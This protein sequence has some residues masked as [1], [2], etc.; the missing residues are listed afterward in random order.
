MDELEISGKRYLSTK[1]AGKQHG[2]H[3]DYIGQLIRG[4]KVTGQKVGRAWYV[5]AQSL[6]Q[7]LDKP[8]HDERLEQLERPVGPAQPEEPEPIEEPKEE[9]AAEEEKEPEP[10][11]EPVVE[12]ATVAEEIKKEE[13]EEPV[14][15]RIERQREPVGVGGLRYLPDDEP[16]LPEIKK[17][18]NAVP[19]V[20]P[21][22]PTAD[23]ERSS[24]APVRTAAS[25][26][27]TRMLAALFIALVLAG[28]SATAVALVSSTSQVGGQTASVY[29]S[30]WVK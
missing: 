5:E 21:A 16:L 13:K 14:A 24:R 12:E 9:P 8:E 18:F 30:L 6:A 1:R 26:S 27:Y 11:P 15:L 28:L 22:A 25:A 7:Y 17:E 29:Y 10:K 3:S 4:G 20:M 23:K 19:S 2:Y